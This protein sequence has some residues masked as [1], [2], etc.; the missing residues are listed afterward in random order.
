MGV[1]YW[2]SAISCQLS[3]IR[4]LTSYILLSTFNF[5]QNRNERQ[6]A[7]KTQRKF[8]ENS[9]RLFA[10]LCELCGKIAG[11]RYRVSAIRN[12]HTFA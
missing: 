2:V 12:E 8:S 3:A 6:E 5:K 4:H 1:G 11:I 10:L 7:K 9:L